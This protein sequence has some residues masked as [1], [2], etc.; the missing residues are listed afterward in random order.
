MAGRGR[1]MDNIF[2]ER[3]WQSLKYEAIYLHEGT[4][5]FK[6]DLGDENFKSITR[7]YPRLPFRMG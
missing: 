4:N 5:G 7:I 3:L 1:C 6:A 2:I